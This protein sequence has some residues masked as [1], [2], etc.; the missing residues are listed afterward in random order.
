MKFKSTLLL[1]V[2]VIIIAAS[3]VC[4]STAYAYTVYYSDTHSV[5]VIRE[6]LQK[7]TGNGLDATY[8]YWQ[9][10]S[11]SPAQIDYI[12]NL[13][14]IAPNQITTLDL[15][16]DSYTRYKVLGIT[17]KKDEYQHL[18]VYDCQGGAHISG[19][20]TIPVKKPAIEAYTVFS[21]VVS[22]GINNIDNE[23]WTIAAN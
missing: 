10:D 6:Y 23:I 7:N 5:S 8:C 22:N 17:F 14:Y 21:C 2:M 11:N 20:Y 13:Y 16:F 4:L 3:V 1:L 12:S 15:Q 18:D 19:Y 9:T